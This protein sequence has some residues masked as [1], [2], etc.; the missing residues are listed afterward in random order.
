MKIFSVADGLFLASFFS[1]TKV[2][3]LPLSNTGSIKVMYIHFK[4][5][6]IFDFCCSFEIPTLVQSSS[7]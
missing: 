1:K 2:Y 4:F 7:S 3:R 5:D 6:L